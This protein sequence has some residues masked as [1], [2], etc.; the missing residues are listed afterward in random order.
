MKAFFD[1]DHTLL[2]T[3]ALGKELRCAFAEAVGQPISTPVW[4]RTLQAA[5]DAGYTPERHAA[6]LFGEG[7]EISKQA[8][9][10]IDASL[11]DISAF[12]F[13][14]VVTFLEKQREAGNEVW[15]VSYGASSWQH[16][17]IGRSGLGKFFYTENII[18]TEHHGSK[19]HMIAD[20]IA[21]NESFLFVDNKPAEVVA[22]A[23][24]FSIATCYLIN[25]APLD[26]YQNEHH[27]ER[28]RWWET[29]MLAESRTQF[30]PL[31][32]NVIEITTLEEI[33]R[34]A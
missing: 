24:R 12:V 13:T 29:I 18:I 10:Q 2:Q 16:F 5:I 30:L 6:C 23:E 31:P 25:R 33:D 28:D 11:R 17:K 34:P 9:A 3:D 8:L 20:N 14:D 22:V 27:P 26:V 1:L 19:A 7:I 4:D 32:R 21:T 15:I